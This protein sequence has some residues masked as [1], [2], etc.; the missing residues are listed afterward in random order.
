MFLLS[1]QLWAATYYM[2]ADGTATKAAA[3]GP[4]GTVANTMSLA[5]HN[6]ATFSGDDIIKLCNDG[7]IFRGQ[8]IPPSSGISGHPITYTKGQTALPTLSG[9]TIIN[10]GSWT[11]DSGSV[12]KSTISWGPFGFEAFE[13]STILVK[14]ASRVAMVAGTFFESGTTLYVWTFDSSSPAGHTIEVA[15]FSGEN[16]G[17]IAVVNKNYITIDGLDIQKSNWIG[18]YLRTTSH[19]T[20]QNSSFEYNYWNAISEDEQAG[21]AD[22]WLFPNSDNV[23]ILSNTFANNGQSRLATNH[24]QEGVA[25]QG[26]GWQTCLIDR[27][28]V[29]TNLGEG[30]VVMGGATNCTMSNNHVTNNKFASIYVLSGPRGGDVTNSTVQY[31]LVENVP[32]STPAYVIAPEGGF[33]DNIN[34]VNFS[35]NVANCNNTSAFYALRFGGSGGTGVWENVKVYNNTL[36]CPYGIDIVTNGPSGPGND[37][38]NNILAS[39]NF[40]T[41]LTSDTASSNYTIGYEDIFSPTSASIKWLGT[42]YTLANFV[43]AFPTFFTHSVQADPKFT[44]AAD[45]SLQAGSPAINSGLNLGSAYQLGLNPASSWPSAISTVNQNSYGSGWEMGAFVFLTAAPNAPT[46]LTG[47]ISLS[48][49]LRLQ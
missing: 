30:L 38:E 36:A 9:T 42:S 27:N 10:S 34:G 45:L 12:Y 18:V 16:S 15:Q 22:A 41:F 17:L 8:L 11:L 48:G 26:L 14:A 29:D 44:N 47:T 46:N 21:G 23:N 5:T 13:D 6:A 1:S 35:Y 39:T 49:G 2:R 43:V 28:I 19:V 40:Q 25:V 32:N 3:I 37:F 7:G 33:G 20:V 4:C 31:N 24:A